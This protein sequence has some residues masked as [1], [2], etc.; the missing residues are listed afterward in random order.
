MVLIII[1]II[2]KKESL[3][4]Y[5]IVIQEEYVDFQSMINSSQS[6]IDY[7]ISKVY[8]SQGYAGINNITQAFVEEQ[9][10]T[11]DENL[12]TNM[13]MKYGVLHHFA[14]ET[15]FGKITQHY[16]MSTLG[17]RSTDSSDIF[18]LSPI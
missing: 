15:T 9:V 3:S 4:G 17:T 5:P 10:E 8:M 7:D 18:K 11:L 13:T 6:V 1:W 2:C 12:Y 16:M 14:I